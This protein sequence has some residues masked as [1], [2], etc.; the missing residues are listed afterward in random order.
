M[1]PNLLYNLSAAF[2][3]CHSSEEASQDDGDQ[4]DKQSELD[5]ERPEIDQDMDQNL[6]HFSSRQ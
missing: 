3:S 1:L 5:H 4:W 2:P 6:R